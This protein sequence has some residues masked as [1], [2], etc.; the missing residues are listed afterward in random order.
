MK[1]QEPICLTC[2]FKSPQK[3]NKHTFLPTQTFISYTERREKVKS[4]QRSNKKPQVLGKKYIHI[5]IFILNSAQAMQKAMLFFPLG[6][7]S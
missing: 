1:A 2:V 6:N 5:Y 7:S 4:F 3:R